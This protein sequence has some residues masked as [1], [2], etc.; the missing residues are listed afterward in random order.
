MIIL[1]THLIIYFTA[2]S[3]GFFAMLGGISVPDSVGFWFTMGFRDTG[4]GNP[5]LRRAAGK[6]LQ[7]L[8]DSIPG[9][10]QVTQA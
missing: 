8:L 1:L 5:L 9:T 6:A 7:D 3:I 10:L 2:R 4:A